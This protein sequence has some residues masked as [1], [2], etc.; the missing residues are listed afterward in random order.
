MRLNFP[1]L[2]Y[3]F[4]IFRVCSL[5]KCDNFVIR[6]RGSLK[7]YNKISQQCSSF[8]ICHC[9]K[10]CTLFGRMCGDKAVCANQ[11]AL[12]CT[13]HLVNGV[14]IRFFLYIFIPLIFAFFCCFSLSFILSSSHTG[15]ESFSHYM[16]PGIFHCMYVHIHIIQQYVKCVYLVNSRWWVYCVDDGRIAAASVVVECFRFCYFPCGH[17]CCCKL[18]LI[19]HLYCTQINVLACNFIL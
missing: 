5:G 8:S 14:H 16:R 6:T 13:Y 9:Q 15:S 10:H 18:L 4:R 7:R 1:V 17:K 11:V 2:R 12:L 3:L 19:R